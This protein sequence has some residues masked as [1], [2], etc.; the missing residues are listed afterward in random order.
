MAA[1]LFDDLYPGIVVGELHRQRHIRETEFLETDPAARRIVV[2]LG[3]LVQ[4]IEGPV[5]LPEAGQYVVVAGVVDV[6]HFETEAH[7]G[8]E[9]RIVECLE[10]V[11]YAAVRIGDEAVDVGES[12]SHR[13]LDAVAPLLVATSSLGKHAGETAC[14]RPGSKTRLG[15]TVLRGVT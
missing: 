4:I 10:E 8:R 15:S 6:W 12:P 11:L 9:V 14:G 13:F 3:V 2:L 1:I 7:G 5:V